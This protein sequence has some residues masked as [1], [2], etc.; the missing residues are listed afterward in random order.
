MRYVPLLL[1]AMTALLSAN[2]AVVSYFQESKEHK[3]LCRETDYVY[4]LLSQE[5]ATIAEF[6]GHTFF[7]LKGKNRYISITGCQPYTN[8]KAAIVF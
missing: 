5:N 4:M 3:V 7:K 1:I 8:K 2:E 6:R